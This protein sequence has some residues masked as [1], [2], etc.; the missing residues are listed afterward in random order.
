MCSGRDCVDRIRFANAS[1]GYA[2]GGAQFTTADGGASWQRS[3]GPNV[4]ALEPSGGD[5][6]RV[7]TTT[8]GCPPGCTFAVQK[9]A[10]GSS[11]W[12]TLKTPMLQGV[13][14]RL[15]RHGDD[16]YV[17]IDQHRSGGAGDAHTTIAVSH[18]RGATWHT[19]P[20]PCS[21]VDPTLTLPESDAVDGA[22]GVDGT[23]VLLCNSR[24]PGASTLR[25]SPD[26]G[27]TFGA[28]IALPPKASAGHVAV[29]A[30]Q[31]V[32]SAIKDAAAELLLSTDGGATF[33]VVASTP[34]PDGSSE[35]F[36]AFTTALVGTWTGPN[37]NQ[38]WR[39]EDGGAT[40]V[41]RTVGS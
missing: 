20:D 3:T 37:G 35:H 9:S 12:T 16:V 30:Q 19:R 34:Q 39:T 1:V 11:T 38:V 22:I 23:L 18:D 26:A 25:I 13:G 28:A 5:V 40:W 17:F 41:E 33:T 32:V 7:V 8:D 6:I 21:P 2:F 36:L 27:E 24:G 14:A 15:L 31:I 10:V 29:G 4:L